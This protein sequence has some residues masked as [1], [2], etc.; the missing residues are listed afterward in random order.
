MLR[1][2]IKSLVK[3]G[4][5]AEKSWPYVIAQF[6]KKPSTACY[7]QAKQHTITSYQRLA[8]LDEMRACLAAGYPFVFGFSVYESFESA[9]V[10]KTGTVNLPKS[11]E[12]LIGGHA[13]CAV[14]Y[15]DNSQRFSVRNSWGTGWGR[16][17]YFTMPYAYVADTKLASDF[18]TVRK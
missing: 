7:T 1:D 14:G 12:R 5:C 13:V 9:A 11:R 15:D 2:G 18:W 16:K 10:A 6:A 4:V 3:Q 17:G 8:T